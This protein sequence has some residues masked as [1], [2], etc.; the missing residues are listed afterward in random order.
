MNSGKPASYW[1]DSLMESSTLHMLVARK[2]E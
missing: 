1:E 2:K